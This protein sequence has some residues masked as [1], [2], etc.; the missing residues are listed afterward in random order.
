MAA[1]ISNIR[2][3]PVLTVAKAV[4]TTDK[5]LSQAWGSD[6]GAGTVSGNE[7]APT[8]VAHGIDATGKKWLY[9]VFHTLVSMTDYNVVLYGYM[10]DE[11]DGT[12]I[13]NWVVVLGEGKN[14]V[15]N[16]EY[17]TGLIDI[18]MWDRIALHVEGSTM[19]SVDKHLKL[20]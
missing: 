13:D 12:S 5:D 2:L 4:H 14:A 18:S 1:V 10:L 11:A 20:Y 6:D 7:T 16:N 8:T 3:V 19:T 9:G 15:G 17:Q